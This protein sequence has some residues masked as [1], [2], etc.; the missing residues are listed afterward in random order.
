MDHT[1]TVVFTVGKRDLEAQSV[2]KKSLEDLRMVR[3]ASLSFYGIKGLREGAGRSPPC[4]QVTVSESSKQ[5]RLICRTVYADT[6]HWTLSDRGIQ[7]Q[8]LPPALDP[9]KLSHDGEEFEPILDDELEMPLSRILTLPCP[10][11]GPE[12]GTA[13][14]LDPFT[15]VILLAKKL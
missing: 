15:A 13:A 6:L 14:P 9:K 8:V 3:D 10:V 11:T 4:I 5:L 1:T 2:G 7:L 12:S